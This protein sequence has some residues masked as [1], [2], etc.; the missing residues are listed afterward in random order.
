MID[1]SHCIWLN[2]RSTSVLKLAQT[3]DPLDES[4]NFVY[5]WGKWSREWSSN[6][7]LGVLV[8]KGIQSD[9]SSIYYCTF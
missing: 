3:L 5:G 2:V 6:S 1:E 9:L 7:S 4:R 8:Q